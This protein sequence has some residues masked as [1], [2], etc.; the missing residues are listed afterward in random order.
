MEEQLNDENTAQLRMTLTADDPVFAAEDETTSMGFLE[1]SMASANR[2]S[3]SLGRASMNLATRQ[4]QRSSTISPMQEPEEIRTQEDLAKSIQAFDEKTSKLPKGSRAALIME[5]ASVFIDLWNPA[6]DMMDPSL[7]DIKGMAP[8]FNKRFIHALQISMKRNNYDLVLALGTLLC[9]LDHGSEDE[10]T[11]VLADL[12]SCQKRS[13]LTCENADDHYIIGLEALLPP[14]PK[15]NPDFYHVLLDKL[16]YPLSNDEMKRSDFIKILRRSNRHKIAVSLFGQHFFRQIIQAANKMSTEVNSE[17]PAQRLEESLRETEY[18]AP[19]VST[20]LHNKDSMSDMMMSKKVPHKP[21]YLTYAIYATQLICWIINFTH[22]RYRE[23]QKLSFAIA[24]GFGLIL[25]VNTMMLYA[26]MA[27]TLTGILY[28]IP[29]V[30][31]LTP[32]GCNIEIHSLVGFLTFMAACG[33]ISA[34]VVDYQL[35]LGGF[36]HSYDNPSVLNGKL[37]W[38]AANNFD[39]LTGDSISGTIL[40]CSLVCMAFTALD[41]GNGSAGYKRFTNV[42]YLYLAWWVFCLLHYPPFGFW[43]ILIGC[44]MFIDRAGDLFLQTSTNTMGDC[45]QFHFDVSYISIPRGAH[46]ALTGTYYRLKVPSISIS[47]WHPISLAGSAHSHNLTFFVQNVGDWTKRL[48][49]ICGDKELRECTQIMVQGPFIAPATRTLQK[50]IGNSQLCVASGVGITPFMSIMAT[51]LKNDLN[52]E[53]DAKLFKEIFSSALI[54]PRARKKMMVGK[55]IRE[56][57]MKKKLTRP[58]VDESPAIETEA[59]PRNNVTSTVNRTFET[60]EGV[61]G[62]DGVELSEMNT[63]G[64]VGADLLKPN[65]ARTTRTSHDIAVAEPLGE[66]ERDLEAGFID[67]PKPL[68]VLWMIRDATELTFYIE[69]ISQ[70]L[71]GQQSSRYP[72]VYINIYLTGLGDGKDPSQLLAQCLYML[73]LNNCTSEYLYINF[74]RPNFNKVMQSLSPDN[75]YY[76]GSKVVK[77]L[78]ADACLKNKVKFHPEDFDSGAKLWPHFKNSIKG[79]FGTETKSK[80]KK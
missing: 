59:G 35:N 49:E 4:S 43:W 34:H 7:L 39:V 72:S 24:K 15:K 19:V 80:R 10:R 27:R 29:I 32:V 8:D 6:G 28:S 53:S 41:R 48:Y 75:C 57:L 22:F 62:V 14:A 21:E 68:Y 31:H 16:D 1:T 25:F 45:R 66:T 63:V 2:A 40:I 46:A 78:L 37:K 77:D 17:M 30:R 61:G 9:T 64:D 3:M 56:K 38:T 26:S 65:E 36:F 12:L 71:N 11:E 55:P 47:E 67:K 52:Y 42:H 54:S 20:P 76:C 50:K 73:S 23:K 18:M 5:H 13:I 79:F 58:S 60:P 74:G 33:H 70:I 51:K 44:L 69:Y